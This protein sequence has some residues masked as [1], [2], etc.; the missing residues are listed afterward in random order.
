MKIFKTVL[1][2][3]LGMLFCGTVFA[4]EK[5]VN[6][7]RDKLKEM[8]VL[9]FDSYVI[10][11]WVDPASKTNKMCEFGI[12]SRSVNNLFTTD[13]ITM[14]PTN[15][16]NCDNFV[17]TN[18]NTTIVWDV[19]GVGVMMWVYDPTYTKKEKYWIDA[20]TRELHISRTEMSY[21]DIDIRK[22]ISEDIPE[23][24]KDGKLMFNIMTNNPICIDDTSVSPI[25]QQPEMTQ[26]NDTVIGS[27]ID[28]IAS[29]HRLCGNWKLVFPRV[30]S[31]KLKND[32]TNTEWIPVKMQTIKG[33]SI[34][35]IGTVYDS[36]G[37]DVNAK[38]LI[39]NEGTEKIEIKM[40][41]SNTGKW[42]KI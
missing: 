4:E 24:V 28:N 15:K 13:Q 9:R 20:A 23:I 3:V 27:S 17:H 7:V 34:S 40:F 6:S 22:S 38:S 5:T 10:W 2:M 35:D 21:G 12:V 33:R 37:N 25:Y 42:E 19:E 32:K 26:M 14:L 30:Q 29:N 39:I 11:R 8:N 16:L 41:N 36:S 18:A 31:F 1:A